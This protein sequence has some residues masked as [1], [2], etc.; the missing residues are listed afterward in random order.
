MSE[1]RKRIVVPP[2]RVL[3]ADSYNIRFFKKRKAAEKFARTK[4]LSRIEEDL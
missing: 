1:P 4:T 3:Y 2:I